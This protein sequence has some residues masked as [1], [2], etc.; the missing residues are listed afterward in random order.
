MLEIGINTNNECGK[1]IREVLTNIKNVGFKN[2]M[3]AYKVG[4]VEETLK[5]ATELSLNVPFVH[6]SISDNLWERGKEN[7]WFMTSLKEQIQLTQKYNIPIAV[8]HATH[9][10]AERLALPPNEFGLERI[11]E[12][13]RFAKKNNVK[14]ALENLDKSSFKHFKYVMDNINDKNLGFCYDA[15]HHQLYIPNVDLLK[16]YGNRILAVHLH[17]NLMDWTYGY[18]WTRDLHR[19][20]YDGK[21]DYNKV[22]RKLAATNYN[23]VIMLELHK[24]NGA[25]IGIYDKMSDIE[26]LKEAKIRAERLADMMENFRQESNKHDKI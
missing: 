5:L 15:G 10:R 7:E 1:D 11:S 22:I 24:N 14:L 19:L 9:G 26:F 18:D 16:R 13:V 17:D 4:N 6:L 23:N 2:V 8:L 3:V 12:L 21:I 25:E 20:P